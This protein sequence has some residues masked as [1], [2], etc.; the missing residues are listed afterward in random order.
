MSV[1]EMSSCTTTRPGPSP[2][3]W[4]RLLGAW[5]LAVGLLIAVAWPVIATATPETFATVIDLSKRAKAQIK[6]AYPDIEASADGKYVA[7]VWSRGYDDETT[8]KEYGYIFLKTAITGTH[9]EIDG[10]ENQVKVFTPTAD[11]WGTS[12]RAVFDPHNSGKLYVTWRQCENQ[13]STCDEILVATC[14]LTGIDRCGTPE[15]VYRE[16]RTSPILVAPDIA[17]DGAGRLHVIWKNETS[18]SLGIQYSYKSGGSWTSPVLVGG[19]NVNS[20]NPAL[21]WGSGGGS[22]GRLHLVWYQYSSS[23]GSR[24]VQYSADDPSASG[25]IVTPTA[26]AQWNAPSIAQFTGG[27]GQEYDKPS[28][29]ASGATVVVAWDAY[30]NST[31]PEEFVLAYDWSGNSGN[32]TS[33]QDSTSSHN[34]MTCSTVG[35]G[36]GCGIPNAKLFGSNPTYESPWQ[37][38][39]KDTIFEERTLRPSVA[40]SGGAPALAWQFMA[41]EIAGGYTAYVI[42]YR[43]SLTASGSI[44]WTNPITI[45]DNLNYDTAT[46]TPYDDSANPDLAM[47]LGSGVHIAHMGMWGGDRSNS[48]SD[49]DIYY[50]GDI[51]KDNSTDGADGVYLPIIKKN[52]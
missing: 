8:T 28:V 2:R 30:K 31:S 19:T 48:A 24:S 38:S 3:A 46:G 27:T 21:V 37:Y 5:S 45:L 47:A 6:S 20:F 22:S 26:A 23:A 41:H 10:W 9:S 52:R 32:S 39:Q 17:A 40:I 18:G 42:A 51:K 15:M 16:T 1:E 12:A 7:T 14:T 4:L 49:W 33:W 34:D 35:E 43:E 13:L 25:W 29:A 36:D 11:V 50:R 44:N